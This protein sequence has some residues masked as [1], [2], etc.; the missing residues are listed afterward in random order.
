MI[1]VDKEGETSSQPA[2]IRSSYN[3][4]IVLPDFMIITYGG[5][6]GSSDY[7]ELLSDWF[8]NGEAADFIIVE[9]G[10][11]IFLM[12]PQDISSLC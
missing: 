6:F 10:S 7:M 2:W 1:F 4:W 12:M 5:E 8:G 3:F 11:G 9:T